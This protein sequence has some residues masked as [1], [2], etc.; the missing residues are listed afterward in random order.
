MGQFWL[1]FCDAIVFR[2]KVTGMVLNQGHIS[3]MTGKRHGCLNNNLYLNRC[4]QPFWGKIR[5]ATYD[6]RSLVT[7]VGKDNREVVIA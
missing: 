7:V 6:C 3:V 1:A 5:Y 4:M 2:R